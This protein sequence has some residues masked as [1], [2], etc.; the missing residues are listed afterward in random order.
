[1]HHRKE[2]THHDEISEECFPALPNLDRERPGIHA[3]HARYA[4]FLQPRGQTRMR[5]PVAVLP[6]VRAHDQPRDVYLVGLEVTGQAVLVEDG[7]VR[8]AVIPDEGEGEHE[9]LPP[10]GRVGEGLGVP[11][12]AGV[13]H[14]L[15]GARGGGAEGSA[16][17]VDRAIVQ[18]QVGDVALFEEMV[19][20]VVFVFVFVLQFFVD[21]FL[22]V[23]DWVMSRGFEGIRESAVRV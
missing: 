4:R 17:D 8:D 16:G 15:A 18:V 6:R 2:N 1:M 19:I 22:I 7:V 21:L 10:V 13:E 11:H 5:R 23:I 20:I 14:H 9:Y 12:H 3:V